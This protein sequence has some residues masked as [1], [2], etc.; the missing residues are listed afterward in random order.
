MDTIWRRIMARVRD[1]PLMMD[2]AEF[3]GLL[4]ELQQSN[5]A[6]DVV[7]KGGC[8]EGGQGIEGGVWKRRA[9]AP[10][11]GIAQHA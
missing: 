9:P 8:K 7:E 6:L 3:A 2:V 4:E 10:V 5:Q 11:L 1:H